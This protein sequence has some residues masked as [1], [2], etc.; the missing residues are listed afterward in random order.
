MSTNFN[1]ML[2]NITEFLRSE[3]KTETIIG[4]QFQ[5][6]EFSCVPVM[7]LGMGFGSA[8]G[9]GK[10]KGAVKGENEGEGDGIG[11]G[12]GGGLSIT[13]IGFLVSREGQIS[14]IHTS[15]SKGL[16]AAFEK[17]PELIEKFMEAQ[18]PKENA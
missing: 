15:T 16:S 3:A 2:G 10:G 1:E 18:R 9:E 11:G 17:V 4:D 6:G 5:L 12:A 14:F 7:S 8:S 13:P